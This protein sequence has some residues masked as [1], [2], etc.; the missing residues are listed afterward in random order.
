MRRAIAWMTWASVFTC[1]CATGGMVTSAN[2]HEQEIAMVVRRIDEARAKRGMAPSLP[3]YRLAPDLARLAAKFEEGVDPNRAL[4]DVLQKAVQSLG[5]GMAYASVGCAERLE[6]L[7][8]P[9][10]L[11]TAN[12]LRVAVGIARCR[13][14]ADHPAREGYCALVAAVQPS[15][16]SAVNHEEAEVR[17]VNVS[18]WARRNQ[19]VGP[20]PLREW[21]GSLRS[22]HAATDRGGIGGPTRDPTGG[23]LTDCADQATALHAVAREAACA[24][25]LGSRSDRGGSRAPPGMG[26]RARADAREPGAGRGSPPPLWRRGDP[27]GHRTTRHRSADAELLAAGPGRSNPC[28][29]RS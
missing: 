8:V 7:E 17:P 9:E 23:R 22:G 28:T 2:A 13:P 10:M 18:R 12:T 1:G 20:A 19:R 27:A 15:P 14:D 11:V 26:A 29:R 5:G 25:V 6:T 4:Q 24:A 16:V 21:L 3:L